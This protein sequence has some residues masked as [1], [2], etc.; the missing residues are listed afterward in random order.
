MVTEAG[1]TTPVRLLFSFTTTPPFD[2]APLSETVPVAAV[3]PGTEFGLTLMLESAAA[4]M[5]NEAVWLVPLRFAV[6]RA[7]AELETPKVEILNV[8]EVE[9]PGTM[10]VLGTVAEL[11]L[12]LRAIGI[13]PGPATPFSV[14]VPVAVFPP[15]IEPGFTK[16]L[17]KPAGLIVR[18]ADWLMP[19]SDPEMVAGVELVTPPVPTENVAEICPDSTLTL[20]GTLAE[21]FALVRVTVAPAGPAGPERVT[22]P[23]LL[24][25]PITD[26]GLR[27]TLANVAGVRFRVV[28]FNCEPR[29]AE[30]DTWAGA[31]TATEFTTNEAESCPA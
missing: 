5:V 9:P 7:V 1:T 19:L 13:P 4:V 27:F 30:I 8:V 3:P 12:E 23:V 31:L 22:V 25:P 2:A 24:A 6:M 16:R 29:L 14:T 10:V 26:V 21:P 11:L 15:T 28:D 20:A 17:A 18:T